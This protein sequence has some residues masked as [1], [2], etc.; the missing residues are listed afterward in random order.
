MA[1]QEFSKR[2]REFLLHGMDWVMAAGKKAQGINAWTFTSGGSPDA[3]TF[4]GAGL[5][6]MADTNYLVIP[7][8]ETAAR[9][10]VDESTKL[11]TGF[12]VLGG[13]ASE[14]IHVVVIGRLGGMPAE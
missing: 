4:A 14:V 3:V 6:D 9:V 13:A 7:G 2:F 10:T 1:L 5:P 8:G 12:S 11:A